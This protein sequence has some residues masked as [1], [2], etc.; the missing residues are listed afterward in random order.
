MRITLLFMRAPRKL[1]LTAMLFKTGFL[2]NSLPLL[3]LAHLANL[4][5][6]S[7]NG[8]NV[9]LYDSISWKLSLYDLYVLPW[10]RLWENIGPSCILIIMSSFLS[11]LLTTYV[12]SS[13][14]LSFG[15]SRSSLPHAWIKLE[16]ESEKIGEKIR[17]KREKESEK[18]RDTSIITLDGLEIYLWC[19]GSY[20]E[21]Q[22]L[23]QTIL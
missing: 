2:P 3:T 15:Y 8:L 18:K 22:V 10:G 20:D 1:S 12:L 16:K 9:T 13:P 5:T 19:I 7:Q 11:P 14:L 21:S 23:S 17:R 4:Q 6:F